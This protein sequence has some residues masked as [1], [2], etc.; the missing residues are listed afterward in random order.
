M[1]NMACMA[2]MASPAHPTEYTF[3][4]A[5]FNHTGRV[6]QELQCPQ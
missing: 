5:D 6:V 2:C 1:T 3:K 4:K